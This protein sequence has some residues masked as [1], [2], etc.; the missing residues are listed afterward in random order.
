MTENW[1]HSQIDIV[2]E[3]ARPVVRTALVQ[4]LADETGVLALGI[5]VAKPDQHTLGV[6]RCI[7]GVRR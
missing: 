1:R 5:I 6:R 4:Y 3:R 7:V 2:E